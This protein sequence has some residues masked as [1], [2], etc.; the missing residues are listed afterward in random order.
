MYYCEHLLPSPRQLMY[1]FQ[2]VTYIWRGH[3]D[4]LCGLYIPWKTLIIFI[5]CFLILTLSKPQLGKLTRLNNLTKKLTK[6]K[7]HWDN[8]HFFDDWSNWSKSNIITLLRQRTF[9]NC[10]LVL[11]WNNFLKTIKNEYDQ[12]LMYMTKN[13]QWLY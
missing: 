1:S 9:L 8:D 2:K 4:A 3:F 12:N 7:I 6:H 10:K 11:Q 13:W 5:F